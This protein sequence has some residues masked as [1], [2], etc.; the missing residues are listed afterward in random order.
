MRKLVVLVL[1]VFG[2]QNFV[3]AQERAISGTILDETNAPLPG[4]AVIIKG[5]SQGSVTDIDGHYQLMIKEADATLVYSLIGYK[6]KEIKVGS[7]NKIDV[8]LEEDIEQ[9]DEVVVTALGI[10]R[11]EKSLGYSVQK[12]QSDQFSETAGENITNS[13]SGRVSGLQVRNSGNMGGSSNIIIRGYSTIGSSNQPLYVVD[14]VPISNS[15]ENE[16]GQSTG[17]GGYDYGDLS[18]DIDPN[19]IETISVL[20][21]ATATALYGSRG[22]NGVIMITTKKG[23]KKKGI[24]V[25]V[26]ANVSFDKINTA[27]MPKYQKEYGAGYGGVG[28]G[29]TETD[30]NGN[31]T[32]N[33]S[34]DASF[35]PK[36]DPN[37][38]VRHWDSFD[39]T[40]TAEYGKTRPYV[41]SEKGPE[42]FYET[43]V[44]QT[45]NVGLDGG[46]ENSNFRLGYT[47]KDIK[48]VLPNSN[49]NRNNINFNASHNLS[50]R[51]NVSFSG[52]YITVEGLG[53]NGTGYDPRNVGQSFNQWFQT[54]LDFDRLKNNYVDAAGNQNTWNR[55][56]ITDGRPAF[57]DNPYWVRFKNYQNDSRDRLY[58]N[59]N[60]NYKLT[61]WWSVT[62]IG[63]IDT[64]SLEQEERIA[65]G[66]TDT[67]QYSIFKKNGKETNFDIRTNI[68]KRFA[69]DLSLT[70]MVGGNV[71][72]QNSYS[73]YNATRGGLVVKDLYAL[74][75]SVS[76]EYVVD[77]EVSSRQVQSIYANASLGWKDMVYLD[78]S[79]RNDWSSTLPPSENSFFYPA[80]STSF[81]FSELN[82]L[83]NSD[84]ISFGKV[85]FGYA[86]VGNDTSPYNT[87]NYY[88][89][90]GK[91]GDV[92]KYSKSSSSVG[93][94]LYNPQLKPE[95]TNELELGLE[96]MFF[97][98]RIGLDLTFYDRTTRNQILGVQTT[99][100]TGYTSQFQNAGDVR[101]KGVEISL[102][103]TP[104]RTSYGLEWNLGFNFG[105]N[106]SEV[107]SLSNGVENL[108][109]GNLTGTASVTAAVGQPYGAIKGTNFKYH[110]NGGKMVDDEG[111]YIYASDAEGAVS[112]DEII[113]NM[114][115]D[116]TGG[117]S[118]S[119]SY[120]GI[121][122]SALI[123]MSIGG[124]I[125]SE[126][127]RYGLSTGLYE[128]TAGLNSKGNPS[129]NSLANGG[130]LLLEGVKEDGSPNDIFVPN[131][132]SGSGSAFNYNQNPDAVY[133]YDAS[134][135]KLRD[136]SIT[137]TLP[138]N[139]ITNSPFNAITLGVYGRNLAILHKNI[140]YFDP[141][142][143][144][145][146]GNVQGFESG[147]NPTTRTFG[148]SVKAKL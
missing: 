43:G 126:S 139:L 127:Y 51:F 2:L 130:G 63:A 77:E 94:T 111:F 53:R 76:P 40:N 91:F 55:R 147:S 37:L 82:S 26:G 22:A 58:G 36:F 108:V 131:D 107:T 136:V 104:V 13:L 6:S 9:L 34:D 93:S 99:G 29:F 49:L 61:D 69:N 85:R 148:F 141:E 35:G 10:T 31:P 45:Y 24:G 17:A 129:R 112:S 134:W 95:L 33:F 135:I 42:H 142:I 66:G 87:T 8:N 47:Y 54:N 97:Q 64:Y 98:R 128:E 123:D 19:S 89:S 119:V 62:G 60:L 74:S 105:K 15:N 86:Q 88:N 71:R 118:T 110:E 14:G 57:F 20:K 11:D 120:K 122:L 102:N 5:T 117:V 145:R 80:V 23:T 100:A 103:T 84:V 92:P 73:L 90:V 50:D 83:K 109:L 146:S 70:A 81:I 133:I 59:F 106:I 48:G 79:A 138:S 96:V 114:Q 124:E 68:N 132:V 137:Y 143:T 67:P 144:L 32:V 16:S 21:G 41:A 113:G 115:P 101:N 65:V 72:T 38:Q 125:F 7:N 18:Q 4:V 39:P 116:W 25:T 46:T 1:L 75:N 27:T 44:T 12:I 56:S 3:T 78:V 140:P 121:R 52:S 30:E 28:G